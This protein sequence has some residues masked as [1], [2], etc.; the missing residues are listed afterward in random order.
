MSHSNTINIHS[1]QKYINA[2]LNNDRSLLEELYRKYSGKIKGMIL[3]NNGSEDDAADIFQEGLLC[4]YNKAKNENFTLTCPFDAFIYL[5]CKNK[6]LNVLNKRV[7][8]K[9]TFTDVEGYNLTEDTVKL[10]E[11]CTLQQDRKNLLE[12]KLAELGESCKKLLRLSWS[13]KSMNEVADE[14]NVTYGYARKK[15]TECMGKLIQLVKQSPQFKSL[16]W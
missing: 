10:A 6:W 3:K 9:V 11:V 14:L 5:I 4:I 8:S 7:T 12:E 2:L 1:D 16:K 13:G 15:K